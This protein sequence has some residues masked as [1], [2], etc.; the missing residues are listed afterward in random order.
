MAYRPNGI[1]AIFPATSPKTGTE[2][3]KQWL[4]AWNTYQS[5]ASPI[6]LPVRAYVTWA[7]DEKG[8]GPALREMEVVLRHAERMRQNGMIS[9]RVS[10]SMLHVLSTLSETDLMQ[11]VHATLGPL[12]E[13]DHRHL[14]DTLW[15]YLSCDQNAA[16]ASEVLYVHRN[17]LMY[18]IRQI[19]QLLDLSLRDVQ[20]LT[21]L[22]TA[23]QAEELLRALGKNVTGRP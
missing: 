18:R 22:W 5:H 2:A 17:T 12:L 20:Q 10:A 4:E 13:P 8:L 15:V 6:P 14:L 19:E 16:R 23:L 11:F 21:S 1:L 9:N 7:R 3:S